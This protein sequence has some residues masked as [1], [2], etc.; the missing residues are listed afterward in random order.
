VR[1]HRGV[2]GGKLR[3]EGN[4]YLDLY[5][6]RNLGVFVETMNISYLL[7]V[8]VCTRKCYS[9]WHSWAGYTY[10]DTMEDA[11]HVLVV[12]V[13][14][15]V[16]MFH[17]YMGSVAVTVTR[18]RPLPPTM[19]RTYVQYNPQQSLKG[20]TTLPRTASSTVHPPEH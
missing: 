5:S 12:D 2:G 7:P 20:I 6:L 4:C 10:T 19:T 15:N 14:R 8:I 9:L 16:Y 11:V 3:I 1:F 17:T 18:F 13:G